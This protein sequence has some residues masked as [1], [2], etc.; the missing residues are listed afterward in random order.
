MKNNLRETK[1]LDFSNEQ[2]QA[3]ISNRKW[4]ELSDAE[5]I[6]AIYNFVRDEIQFGYNISDDISA[7]EVLKDAYGQC[8]TK[9]TLLMALLRA[10]NIPNRI[11]A[12]TIDKALQKG[13]ITGLRYLLAP[14]NILHTW[15]E[16][17]INEK[18]YALEGV[19]LDKAYLSKLQEKN[20]DSKSKFCGFG[21]YTNNFENPPIDWDFNDTYIQNLGLTQ[22]LGLFDT[23]DDFYKS[24]QQKIG[25][26]KNFIFKY[27]ARHR[28]NKIVDSIREK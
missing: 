27:F 12:S 19:I 13:V 20:R 9:A 16:V 5:R 24:H 7:S 10:V 3:L 26:I 18:W 8:N 23:P 15:V 28:M 21:V 25:L 14:Q 1:M 4:K 6:K 22:D 17:Y 11:H 2:I